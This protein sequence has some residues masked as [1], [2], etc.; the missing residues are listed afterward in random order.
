MLFA[1]QHFAHNSIIAI[2]L[3][4]YNF[5]VCITLSLQE[6][7]VLREYSINFHV[8]KCC[9]ETNKVLGIL[10]LVIF[11]IWKSVYSQ[12]VGLDKAFSFQEAGK[13]SEG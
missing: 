1:F 6:W 12:A 2:N 7:K 13:I 9:P 11:A 5:C 8:V 3:L 10:Y 4:Y